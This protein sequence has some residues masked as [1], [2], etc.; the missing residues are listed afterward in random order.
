MIQPLRI[1]VSLQSPLRAFD[2]WSPDLA[3]LLERAWFDRHGAIGSATLVT[4]GGLPLTHAPIPLAWSVAA[5]GVDDPSMVLGTDWGQAIAR[6]DLPSDWFWRA[7][8]PIY[9]YGRIVEQPIRKAYR[10]Q[11]T[12]DLLRNPGKHNSQAGDYKSFDLRSPGRWVSGAITWFAWGNRDGV[13]DLLSRVETIGG[14]RKQGQGFV[15]R[16]GWSVDVVDHAPDLWDGDRLM[17]PYPVRLMGD[18]P[19]AIVRN[20]CWR[21]PGYLRQYAETCAMPALVKLDT[22]PDPTKIAWGVC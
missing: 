5:I 8:A 22:S 6:A 15:D 12:W 4:E 18:R 10:P 16:H 9:R 2:D 21:P 13:T 19:T 11:H 17:R 14:N 7:S 20:W 1:Q 3:A